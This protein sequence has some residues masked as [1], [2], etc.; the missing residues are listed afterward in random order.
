MKATMKSL[1]LNHTCNRICDICGKLRGWVGNKNMTHAK[2]SAIRKAR[3][4]AK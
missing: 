4:F 3:G 2:C 1:H